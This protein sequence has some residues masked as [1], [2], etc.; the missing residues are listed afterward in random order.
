[1]IEKK[2]WFRG[3]WGKVCHVALEGLG[4]NLDSSLPCDHGQTMNSSETYNEDNSPFFQASVRI[5]GVMGKQPV[6]CT[7]LDLPS[8]LFNFLTQLH[9]VCLWAFLAPF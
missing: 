3:I 9:E 4:L 2:S 7:L 6:N 5:H 1:M 8:V